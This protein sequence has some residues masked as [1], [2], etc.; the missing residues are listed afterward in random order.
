VTANEPTVSM[1]GYLYDVNPAGT[2]SFMTVAP[3]TVTGLTAGASKSVT[4]L[5]QPIAWTV[6]TGD[7]VVLV[8]DSGDHRWSSSNVKNEI[9]QITSTSANPSELVL[10]KP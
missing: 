1:V 4:L 5:F 7:H 2:A 8:V 3:M 10:P 9:L 6:P